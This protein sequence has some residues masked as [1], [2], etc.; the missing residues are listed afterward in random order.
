MSEEKKWY[1]PGLVFY[2]KQLGYQQIIDRDHQY[3]RHADG[4][5]E[6]VK[7]Q[8]VADFSAQG[9]YGSFVPTAG[10]DSEGNPVP[11]MHEEG[12]PDVI[13]NVAG[14]VWSL[15]DTAAALNWDDADKETAARVMLKLAEDPRFSDFELAP[16]PKA[17]EAPWG[18]YDDTHH[19]KIP[20]LAEELDVVE[21]ALAYER[22][23]KNRE[24]V[25]KA[26]EDKLNTDVE[27]LAAV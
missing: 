3:H 10:T 23:T 8:K 21:A 15:D 25:V 1:R 17:P 12:R 9:I 6:I 18:N 5:L 4:S 7:T 27:E 13:H 11:V 14:G 26:L 16:E 2:S 24:G 20:N 22:Y 19:F